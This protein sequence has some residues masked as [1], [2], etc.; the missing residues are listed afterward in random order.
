MTCMLPVLTSRR[1]QRHLWI[2]RAGRT[3]CSVIINVETLKRIPY[4]EKKI[5]VSRHKIH[6]QITKHGYSIIYI[7]VFNLS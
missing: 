6:K 1:L 5:F 2:G 3:M 7:Y 4:Q